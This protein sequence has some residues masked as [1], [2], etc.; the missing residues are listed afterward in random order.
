MATPNLPNYPTPQATTLPPKTDAENIAQTLA[1]VLPDAKVLIET[2]DSTI[3][4]VALP[5]S[6]SL[7]EVDMERFFPAPRRTVLSVETRDP[8]S[9]LAYLKR[10]ATDD[11]AV[12]VAFD[13]EQY[14]LSISAVFDDIGAKSHPAWRA[15]RATYKPAMSAAWQVWAKHNHKI[16]NQLE[17]AEFLER[18]DRDIASV[19]GMPTHLEMLKMATEFE[20]NGE[21]R[22]KS[23]LRLQGGGVRLE[24][25]DDADADTLSQMRI[26]DRFAI[27]IP[28]FWGGPP[29]Q[30]TA[31]LRY[32]QA[33]GKVNFWYEL[34]RPEAVHEAAAKDAITAIRDG[35][36][37]GVE[38][39]VGGAG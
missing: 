7:Q 1:R 26:F 23:A 5:K 25:V 37:E 28:V 31:R 24:Y 36:P 8:E 15:H 11:T 6:M 39:F 3:M 14:T 22:I 10:H 19:D 12:W 33:A 34:I 9:F 18:N 30:L 20:A 29:F 17:F 4:H 27:G 32:R 2:V 35:L 21:R 13:P 16:Q 38:M